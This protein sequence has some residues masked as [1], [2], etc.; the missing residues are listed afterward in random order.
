MVVLST[1]PSLELAQRLATSLVGDRLAAC[2][3][4][5]PGV[6]SVYRFQGKIENDQEWLLVMKTRSERFPALRE[7]I[8]KAHPYEIPE[9]VALPL[10]S[11]HAPYLAWLDES[12]AG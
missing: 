7:A 9:V 4:I 3:S 8:L 10:E 1:V 12:V 6:I 11:G 5:V 2:V